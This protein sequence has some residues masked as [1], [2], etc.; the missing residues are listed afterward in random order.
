MNL[1]QSHLKM[2]HAKCSQL[3]YIIENVLKQEIHTRLA[4]IEACPFS[5]GSNINK[6]CGAIWEEHPGD[7]VD[8]FMAL[9][10]SYLQ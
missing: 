3:L 2:S 1:H 5:M 10:L 8:R 9:A 6:V 7:E 4:I